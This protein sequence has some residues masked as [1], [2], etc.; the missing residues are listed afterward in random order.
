MNM[1]HMQFSAVACE[2][3]AHGVFWNISLANVNALKESSLQLLLCKFLLQCSSMLPKMVGYYLQNFLCI[4]CSHVRTF[5]HWMGRLSIACGG[6]QYV[7]MKGRRASRTEAP[8]FVI[9]PHSTLLDGVFIFLMNECPGVIA[10][11]E[12]IH[13]PFIGSKYF[14]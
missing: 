8:I 10:K 5:V 12:T 11:H 13:Q 9:A 4:F 14:G 6:F 1:L 2:G 7:K 3:Q